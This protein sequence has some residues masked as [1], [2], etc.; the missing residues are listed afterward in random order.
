MYDLVHSLRENSHRTLIFSQSTKVL[1]IIQY[2]LKDTVKLGRIDGQTKEKDRQRFVDEFNNPESTIEAMLISTKAGGQ[3][4]TLT[5]ADTVIVYDPSWNPAEDSQAVDRCYRIGQKKPVTVYRLI[6]SGTVEEKRY[7]KQIHKDGLRRTIL[8]STGND[9]AKYFTK[10]ELLRRQVFVLGEEGHCEFLK[11]LTQR[12]FNSLEDIDPDAIFSDGVVGQSSHDIVYS[13]PEN[14]D[15]DEESL[16]A[17]APFSSP[18]TK[19]TWYETKNEKIKQKM[20]VGRSQRVLLQNEITEG[21]GKPEKEN[22][23][24]GMNHQRVMIDRTMQ[25]G[26]LR[27]KQSTQSF[28]EQMDRV[29]QLRASGNDVKAV[30][31]MMDMLNDSYDGLSSDE[32]M[33]LHQEI[34]DSSNGLKWL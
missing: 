27:P 29:K 7:E 18:S 11:K 17:P 24:S 25:G 28:D 21:R 2:V 12:G 22:D 20:V 19:G 10:E 14:W 1:D 34:A 3:G 16:D 6:T 8:T 30:A 13:L 9:T 5:G 15:K 26:P 32:K 33:K 4:L 23:G 31:C